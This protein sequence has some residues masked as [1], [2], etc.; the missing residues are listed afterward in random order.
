MKKA[1]VGVLALSYS[2]SAI[3]V[4]ESIY[5]LPTEAISEERQIVNDNADN[6]GKN[7]TKAAMDRAMVAAGIDVGTAKQPIVFNTVN[8]VPTISEKKTV[9]PAPQSTPVDFN[10]VALAQDVVSGRD[11]SLDKIRKKYKS[12][13]VVNVKAGHTELLPIASGMTN[14][15]WTNFDK[16]K[17]TTSIPAEAAL[18]HTDGSFVYIVSGAGINSIDLMLEEEGAPETAINLTLIPLDVPPVMIE[19]TVDMDKSQKK[20]QRAA[21]A[22]RKEEDLVELETAK[23]AE[24]ERLHSQNSPNNAGSHVNSIM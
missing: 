16:V 9:P 6:A 10:K 12:H 15:I 8:G 2:L 1:I 24:R 14:R 21:I 18:I 7:A 17:K 11:D 13:Q 3:A 4:S 5:D 20:A 23:Q 19:L 22:D